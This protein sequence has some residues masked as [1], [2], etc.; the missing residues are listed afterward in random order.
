MRAAAVVLAPLL[1]LL[2]ASGVDYA[3]LA[4][5]LK[6]LI[7]EQARIELLRA[8]R[9]DTDSALSALSG[10]HRKDVRAWR[11]GA[12][13]ERVAQEASIGSQVFARWVQDPQYRDRNRRPRPLPRHGAEPSFETLARSVTRDVHPYTVLAELAR[14]G[15]VRVQLVKG[16]EMVLPNRD[17]FVPPAGSPEMLDLFG[18]NLADHARAAVGNLLGQDPMLEQ[19][20]FADG[21]SAESARALSD[22][23]RKLW[24]QARS[25]MIAEALRLYDADQSRAAGA[26]AGASSAGSSA[27]SST[28]SST[29][30]PAASGGATNGATHR[31]RFGAYYWAEDASADANADADAGAEAVP[32]APGTQAAG[33]ESLSS[34]ASTQVAATRRNELQK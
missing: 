7:L 1:R 26:A 4:A 9:A 18:A 22:L 21:I 12:L 5:R 16:V 31:V 15:L 3:Q 20:V 17:G 11:E 24:A 6:P 28:G 29:V 23:A 32:G 13:G 10:I 8:G 34:G 14:L 27:G 25:E 19:S 33:A 2:L 30:T